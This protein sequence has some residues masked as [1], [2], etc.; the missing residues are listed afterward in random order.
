MQITIL[1]F[2]CPSEALDSDANA[3]GARPA[4][5]LSPAASIPAAT[6]QSV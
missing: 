1:N 4:W 5:A 3:V 6:E 2:S